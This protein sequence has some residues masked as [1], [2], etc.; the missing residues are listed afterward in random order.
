MAER[1]ES[2][3]PACGEETLD[4]T[5]TSAAHNHGLLDVVVTC[6]AE[7]GGCGITRSGFIQIGQMVEVD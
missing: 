6:S 1:L 5:V 2:P 7:D 4:A 3:C